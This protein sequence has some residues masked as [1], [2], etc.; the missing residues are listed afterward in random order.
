MDLDHEFDVIVAG[1]GA[2]GCVLASRLS[3]DPD[4]HVLLLE[5]GPD[6]AAPGEEH[7]DLL[8]PFGLVAGRNADFFWPGLVAS[9]NAPPADGSRRASA[10]WL[11]G[12]SVG[13]G[14][15]VN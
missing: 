3:E 5:A 9:T 1:G 7:P 2:A 10:A 12:F 14:S 6:A 8:D 13:G 4:K 11:Q 15:N